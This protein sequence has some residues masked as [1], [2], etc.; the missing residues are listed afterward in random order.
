[1]K[2]NVVSQLHYLIFSC[3]VAHSQDPF[4]Q[5]PHPGSWQLPRTFELVFPSPFNQLQEGCITQMNPFFHG[6]FLQFR[7]KTKQTFILRISFIEKIYFG[8]LQILQMPTRA[9]N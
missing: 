8:G 7:M 4:M 9:W 2:Q 5:H 6:L 3:F 1:M